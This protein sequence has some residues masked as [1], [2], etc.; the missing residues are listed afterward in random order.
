[1]R[2]GQRR[3]QRQAA[4]DE[5]SYDAFMHEA[6]AGLPSSTIPSAAHSQVQS[7]EQ[8]PSAPALASAN[9][10]VF[11]PGTGRPFST[12]AP[13]LDR[14][15]PRPQQ[16]QQEVPGEFVPGAGGGTREFYLNREQ[17]QVRPCGQPRCGS[18]FVYRI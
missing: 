16:P 6:A 11:E 7:L 9:F 14:P 15:G 10:A 8:H 18:N 12:F 5:A 1:M 13:L 4:V 3:P 2:P 17:S